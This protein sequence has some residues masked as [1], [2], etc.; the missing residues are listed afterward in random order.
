MTEQAV[1][2]DHAVTLKVL[3]PLRLAKTGEI[4][5]RAA[6]HLPD[7]TDAAG[8]Q[9][10]GG[11]R[12]DADRDIQPFFNKIGHAVDE[13]GP[14]LHRRVEI[15]EIENDGK[16]MNAPEQCR[17]RHRE[18]PRRLREAARR[19]GFRLGDLGEDAPAIGEI[20]LAGRRQFQRPGGANEEPRADLRFKLSDRPRHRR[21]ARVQQLGGR[22]K[23]AALHHLHEDAH[24]L[25]AIH[26]VPAK[27][28][29]IR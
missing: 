14:H 5:R 3:R 10:R 29:C 17:R 25:P 22:R 16:H 15:E 20:A 23:A 11:K 19:I 21:R 13:H 4:I 27:Y 1:A 6:E 24:R 28:Y 18:Q 9:T 26:R 12:R 7:R 2:S 8:N